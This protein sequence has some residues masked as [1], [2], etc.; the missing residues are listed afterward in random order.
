MESDAPSESPI[1][2]RIHGVADHPDYS[3]LGSARLIDDD[4]KVRTRTVHAPELPLHQLWLFNWSRTSRSVA[5]FF[6]YVALPFTLL[7]VAGQT[8]STRR[9]ADPFVASAVL[10][11]GIVMSATAVIWLIAIVETVMGHLPISTDDEQGVAYLIAVLSALSL[12]LIISVRAHLGLKG[13]AGR[14]GA[15]FR[16]V[17]VG[18][19]DCLTI[20]VLAVGLARLRPGQSYWPNAIRNL[21]LLNV[22]LYELP[23]GSHLAPFPVSDP[24]SPCHGVDDVVACYRMLFNR[25]RGNPFTTGGGISNFLDVLSISILLGFVVSV[26]LA[27]LLLARALIVRFNRQA[28]DRHVRAASLAAGAFVVVAAWVTLVSF[29]S[30]GRLGIHWALEAIAAFSPLPFFSPPPF[31]TVLPWALNSYQLSLINGFALIGVTGLLAFIACLGIG[32]LLLPR[33]NP[34]GRGRFMRFSHNTIRS[35]DRLL[36]PVVTSAGIFW[37][38]ASTLFVYLHLTL[39]STADDSARDLA[40]ALSQLGVLIATTLGVGSVV[41]AATLGRGGSLHKIFDVIADVIGFWPLEWHPLS[42]RSYRGIVIDGLWRTVR[43]TSGRIILAGHSQGSVIAFWFVLHHLSGP[44]TIDLIT[45]GSPLQSLYAT[46]F[47]SFFNMHAYQR[48]LDRTHSWANVWRNTDPIASP[49]EAE[50]TAKGQRIRNVQS[51][52]PLSNG[53]PVRGHSDYWTDDIQKRLI[54]SLVI[55]N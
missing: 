19:I 20:L 1:E 52:D 30:A 11:Q 49:L 50:D 6:W 16:L 53:S 28:E 44:R 43:R 17:F 41:F 26:I 9:G 29:A 2:I 12:I 27:I 7:N 47:P 42:G 48:V 31:A 45:C 35:L 25:S 36:L 13:L 18:V 34:R 23:F 40:A 10:I 33:A 54:E 22:D 39:R 46:T 15:Q 8:G 4:R 21:P 14:E 55:R 5:G 32:G 37:I 3:S 38:A 24:D 51:T